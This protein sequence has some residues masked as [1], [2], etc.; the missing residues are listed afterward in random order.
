M[1]VRKWLLGSKSPAH[2]LST[3][4]SAL[5]ADKL[6]RHIAV[7]MDGNGR[8][9]KSRGF[10]RLAGHKA[11]VESVREIVRACSELSIPAMTLYSFSTEN[12]LRPK[13]EVG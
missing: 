11:G 13:Q 5:S 1:G 8:W 2:D 7:I 9:A 10:P 12:W 4:H 3:Q 6:P